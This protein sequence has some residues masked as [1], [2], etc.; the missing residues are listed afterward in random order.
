MFWCVGVSRCGAVWRSPHGMKQ[1]TVCRFRRVSVVPPTAGPLPFHRFLTLV[2][3]SHRNTSGAWT[4]RDY[5]NLV[6]G[7][8]RPFSVRASSGNESLRLTSPEWE[9]IQEPGA[10]FPFSGSREG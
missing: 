5:N 9:L 10:C 8:L 1:V 2:G 3:V 6:Q 4:M 7:T